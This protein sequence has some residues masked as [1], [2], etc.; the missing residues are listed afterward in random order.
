MNGNPFVSVIQGNFESSFEV[1]PTL[2]L[3]A[4][5][6]PSHALLQKLYIKIEVT[7][8]LAKKLTLP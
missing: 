7:L 3:A 2:R 6:G 8:S 5:M 1:F 4:L